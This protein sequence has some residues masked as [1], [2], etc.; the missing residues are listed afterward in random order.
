MQQPDT[1][2]SL[3][4]RNKINLS[5]WQKAVDELRITA[6]ISPSLCEARKWILNSRW[7]SSGLAYK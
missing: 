6:N 3:N 1:F 4:V 7:K 5:F 2:S